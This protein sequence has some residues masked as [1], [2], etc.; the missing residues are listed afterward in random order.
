MLLYNIIIESCS[1][2]KEGGTK[3]D[4]HE[5]RDA[6]IYIIIESSIVL[7]KVKQ[8]LTPRKVKTHL[9]DI[10]IETCG[11]LKEGLMKPE[12]QDGQGA[13]IVTL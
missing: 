11:S 13:P 3:I 10:I 9:Y 6:S 8:N 12:S 7:R 2:S 1:N 5:G 4:S